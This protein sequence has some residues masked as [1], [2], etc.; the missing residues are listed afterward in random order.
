MPGKDAAS[1]PQ[2]RGLDSGPVRAGQAERGRPKILA[3][4]RTAHYSAAMPATRTIVKYAVDMVLIFAPLSAA[5]YFLF[6]PDAFNAFLAW[7]VRVL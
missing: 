4:R 1:R 3:S 6:D 2:R 7:L 5:I